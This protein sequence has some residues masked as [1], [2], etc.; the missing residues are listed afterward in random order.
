MSTKLKLIVC[1]EGKTCKK[2][3]AREILHALEEALDDYEAED[4]I[5][6]KKSECLGKCGRGPV[7]KVKSMDKYV[8]NLEIDDCFD[9]VKAL[10]KKH[11]VPKKLQI[12]G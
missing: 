4:R 8:G 11:K 10:K 6:L 3:G 1:T 12:K 2:R 9:L 7:A 5:C